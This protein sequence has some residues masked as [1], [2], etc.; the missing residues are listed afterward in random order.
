MGKKRYRHLVYKALMIAFALVVIEGSVRIAAFAGL[1][2]IR[3]FETKDQLE[4]ITFLGDVN[5]HFGAW[6]LTNAT[7]VVK[8][9]RGQVSYASNSFGM[10]DRARVEATTAPER[11]VVLGDSF[12]EGSHVDAADRVTDVLEKDTGVEFLNFG[13]AGHFGSIQ[14]WMLYKHLA[15]RFD[16]TLVCLFLLPDNDFTDND[17][18]QHSPDRYRPYLR[19]VDGSYEVTYPIPFAAPTARQ[20][21]LSSGRKFRHR[22]YNSWYSLNLIAHRDV[23]EFVDPFRRRIITSYDT[24][25]PTDLARLL[26][27]YQQIVALANKRP[28][29][30]FIIP[31]DKDFMAHKAGRF[32][33]RIAT[34]LT[35]FAKETPGLDVVDLMPHFLAYA[36]EHDVSYKRFFLAFDPHWSPLGHRV[37]ADAV[38]DALQSHDIKGPRTTL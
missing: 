3:T 9:P 18:A 31:R 13:T 7:V 22:M 2:N 16:H 37:A 28:V 10:R 29:Y 14:E 23:S 38:L 33:G 26:F 36:E 30:I 12:V 35:A 21:K 17:P 20:S 5:P 19:E 11:A 32:E 27:T 25:T 1:C 6:H 8:N 24:Y 15:I 34:A 4:E